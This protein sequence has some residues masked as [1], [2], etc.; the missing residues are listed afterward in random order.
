ME[1]RRGRP[2]SAAPFV[3]FRIVNLQDNL[4]EVHRL[5]AP[6]ADQ[7]FRHHYKSIERLGSDQ[8]VQFLGTAG[9]PIT[10]RDLLP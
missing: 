3:H 5:P 4:L 10:I 7:P 8:T 1:P 9:E 6:M 2:I